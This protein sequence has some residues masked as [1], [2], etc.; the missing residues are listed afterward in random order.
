[1][2]V[3]L[4][5]MIYSFSHLFLNTDLTSVVVIVGVVF[6]FRFRLLIKLDGEIMSE[7]AISR[8]DLQERRIHVVSEPLK[9]DSSELAIEQ[10]EHHKPWVMKVSVSQYSFSVLFI[11]AMTVTT[12]TTTTKTTT[13]SAY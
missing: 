8:L 12:T 5:C 7:C 11:S 2:P 13:T 4:L 9:R 3:V 6:V 1:M 10:R